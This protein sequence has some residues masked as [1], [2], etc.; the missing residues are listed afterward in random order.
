MQKVKKIKKLSL[1]TIFSTAFRNEYVIRWLEFP[2]MTQVTLQS[3]QKIRKIKVEKMSLQTTAE[4]GQMWLLR[5][6]SLQTGE[7]HHHHHVI[8]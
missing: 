8:R 6:S 3:R 7:D 4:M 1:M 2:I 5:G